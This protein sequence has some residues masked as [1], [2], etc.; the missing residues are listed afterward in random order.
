MGPGCRQFIHLRWHRFAWP[1]FK[2]NLAGF[3]FLLLLLML[4][5]SCPPYSAAVEHAVA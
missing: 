4:N 2:T 3:A 5:V 1:V